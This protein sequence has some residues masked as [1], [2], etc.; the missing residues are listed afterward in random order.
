[1]PIHH[2]RRPS[3][4][5]LATLAGA[6]AA[7][8][9]L[10]ACGGGGQ[11]GARAVAPPP[12]DTRA[13]AL[14]AT[15]TAEL[16]DHV[17]LTGI[18]LV[19]GAHD[20]LASPSYKAASQAVD[21]A[22]AGL[23]RTI[24][25]ALGPA[26]GSRFATVWSQQLG[27]FADYV[28]AR[29]GNDATSADTAQAKLDQVQA[30]AASV[31][32]GAAPQIARGALTDSLHA[33]L[34][35]LTAAVD[36]ALAR[37]PA[38]YARL[39]DAAEH[40][41][42]TATILAAGLASHARLGSSARSG[43]AALRGSLTGLLVDHAYLVALTADATLRDGKG[44]AAAHQA[45]SALDGAGVAVADLISS[46][47]GSDAAQDFGRLL[48]HQAAAFADY[49][50]AKAKKDPLDTDAAL[51]AL[52]ASRRDIGVLFSNLSPG[53]K[54]TRIAAAFGPPVTALTAAIRADVAMSDKAFGRI[55]DAA[56]TMP[57]TAQTIARVITRQFPKRFPAEAP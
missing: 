37:S 41:P 17:Y 31:L 55:A 56:D 21:D 32:A 26:T 52:D 1:M 22:S 34:D 3:R 43:A 24:S 35:A 2:P 46:A 48:G 42:T 18:A 15:L 16:T 12:S 49:T 23:A 50:D 25:G 36:T 14:R 44:S 57:A 30:D 28:K 8:S 45:A 11:Q 33:D 20:G 19:R 38:I 51:T 39:Q 7:A 27:L 6:L 5:A 29:L 10:T 13:A 47:Y 54:R 53:L 9:V 4:R 40:V